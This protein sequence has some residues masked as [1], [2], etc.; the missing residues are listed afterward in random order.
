MSTAPAAQVVA[1]VREYRQANEQSIA[2]ELVDFLSIPNIA[3]DTPN[4]QRNAEKLK[5]M[6]E[7]RGLRVQFLPIA[8]RG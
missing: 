6:L 5:S 3:T 7:A 8:G 1:A 2:R 4:I